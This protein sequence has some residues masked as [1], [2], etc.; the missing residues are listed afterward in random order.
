[1]LYSG[2]ID[3]RQVRAARAILG[4]TL[5]DIARLAGLNR[6]SVHRL[7]HIGALPEFSYAG[8]KL[9]AARTAGH[10][11]HSPGWQSGSGV[12]AGLWSPDWLAWR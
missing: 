1:M 7:E 2:P 3:G 4:M 9:T 5:D 12:H 10:C 8:S 6:N 11:L